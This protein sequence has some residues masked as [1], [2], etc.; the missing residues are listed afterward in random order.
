MSA[1]MA[2]RT[3]FPLAAGLGALLLC[4]ALGSASVLGF[5]PFYFWL[6]PVLSL[7]VLAWLIDQA[8]AARR[9]AML[10]FC[11]G[12]GYFVTGV[13]WIYVSMTEFG[14]MAVPL[15]AFA[16]LFFCSYLALFPAGAAWV[17]RRIPAGRGV[18]LTLAF[19][20]S[21]VL[22]EWVRGWM[23]TGFPWLGVGYS[24][25]PGGPL[26]GYAPVLGV[27]GVSLLAALSAGLLAWW[28]PWP[29]AFHRRRMLHP[30]LLAAVVLWLA[31]LG[32]AQVSWTHPSGAPTTVSL[33]QGNIRQDLKW[34]PEAVQTTLET[35]LRLTR[36]S[37]SR[38]I[39]LPETAVPLLNVEVPP[40]YLELLAEHA[41]GNVG[42]VL[43][44]IPEYVEGNPARYY[45][46]VMSL[47]ISPTGIYRKH[48][49]VPFGD[50]FPQWTFITWVMSAMQIP[51][52]SF[53]RG[54]AVQPPL[55][56][57]GQHVAVNICYEDAFG[58]ELIRQLPRATIL[59]NFTNDAWWGESFASE[60][61]LQISQTRAQET[62]RYMLR[63]TNTGVTAIIDQRGRVLAAAPQFVTTAVDGIAQGYAG[64]TPYVRWGNWVVLGLIAA[65]LAAAVALRARR[66]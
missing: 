10:G 57:A 25:S 48:H 39:V 5:A 52:S 14:G 9:A 38:L 32:L 41:R 50:Y 33:L 15:A 65:M 18:R 26:A 60:Q 17:A 31:G 56:V 45:N 11:F 21:W 58:E 59:A 19:P 47:G 2:A 51:M 37:T 64:S 4:A 28:V 8:S 7:G 66:D 55:A 35:Y 1:G 42:D 53:S 16:T 40:G 34:R 61:H 27:Y 20:A 30:G 22:M 24:Q 23:F 12:L 6:V 54:D 29:A 62:G 3:P 36:A 43:L 49:L 63:A 44:G 46:G 13:S